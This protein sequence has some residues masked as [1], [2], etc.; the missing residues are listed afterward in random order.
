LK[1][2]DLR[3]LLEF[4]KTFSKEAQKLAKFGL[5]EEAESTNRKIIERLTSDYDAYTRLGDA[6]MKLGDNRAADNAYQSS[7]SLKKYKEEN[8]RYSI[9]V[10]MD[11]LWEEAVKINRIITEDFPWELEGHNRF[12]KS[13][14]ETGHKAQ[15][16]EAFRCALILSPNNPI[17]KKN[18]LRLQN[19][20]TLRKSKQAKEKAAS[21][22]FIEDSGKTTMTRLV[23]VP[24]DSDFAKF[25]PGN[26]VELVPNSK[27]VRVRYQDSENVGTLEPK[28]GSRIRKLMDGGNK[29]EASITSVEGNAITVMIREVHRDPSQA[30]ISSFPRDVKDASNAT[31]NRGRYRL[32]EMEN[33]FD[34]KD[35]SDDDVE[36]GGEDRFA[37]D[38][39]K[40]FSQGSPLNVDDY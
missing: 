34:I 14:L 23:N 37:P 35:W 18:L 4:R 11:S 32:G 24:F 30:R 38:L 8:T 29:Y 27:S 31:S 36:S 3:K 22:N 13:L 15:G 16:A 10:A 33:L 19:L 20:T 2:N 17:A 21:N 39:P 28:I 40:L 9:R 7:Q 6:L 25:I 1:A 12:G 5:W 26:S